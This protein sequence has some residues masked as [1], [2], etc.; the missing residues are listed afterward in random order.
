M[1]SSGL[2]RNDNHALVGYPKFDI[3]DMKNMNEP[4]LFNNSNPTV[5]YNPHFEAK[6]SSW[7]EMG[8]EVLKFFYNR[9]D[10]NLI[11]APHVM[12]F[13]RRLHVSLQSGIFKFVKSIPRKY[14]ECPT[15]RIDLGS[16]NSFNMKYTLNADIYL[17][18]VSSQ[19]YEF[20][21]KP[22]PCIFLNSH[23]ANWIKNPNYLHWHCGPVINKVG[24]L[25]GILNE[26]DSI[27]GHYRDIQIQR[28]SETFDL[29]SEPSSA[30]AAKAIVSFLESHNAAVT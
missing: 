21:Y 10:Y 5:L 2:I 13:K 23:Q 28:F 6:L 9:D 26:L 22:K 30:R 25:T 7:H 3:I 19:I 29:T 8:I 15:I 1:L 16:M 17:G 12:L 4:S 18:D 20:L 14:W 11:L 24:D 27:H